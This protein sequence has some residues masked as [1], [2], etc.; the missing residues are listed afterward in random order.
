MGQLQDLQQSIDDA[1]DYI[2]NYLCKKCAEMTEHLK[3]LEALV[4]NLKKDVQKEIDA[5]NV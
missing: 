2:D 1:K 5:N 4:D 3:S